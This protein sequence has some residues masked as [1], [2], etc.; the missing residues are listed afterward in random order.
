MKYRFH[1]C[2]VF[3]DRMF[4]GNQLA[5][6]PEAEGLSTDQMQQLTREFNFSEC[7]FVLPP[8]K[9]GSRRVRIFTPEREVP[10]AGHPNVGTAFVLLTEG[11]AES[12]ES[13]PLFFE[14]PAGM[15][16]V[17]FRKNGGS[18]ICELEA[19]EAFSTGIRL[20]PA[21]VAPSV[22]LSPDD[23]KT[24]VHM[25]E[26]ASVGFPFLMTEL[27]SVDALRRAEPDLSAMKQL[28]AVDEHLNIHLYVRSSDEYDLRTR[29]FAPLD[30]IFE[31]PATG[32]ANCA[33]AAYLA[34][35]E[36][37]DSCSLDLRI[38]Q[39]IEMGRPSLLQAR[40]LKEQG[41][42]VS[43]HIGGNCVMVTS[44]TVDLQE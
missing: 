36:P 12:D 27:V 34:S 4:G 10:F 32:S 13:K 25:P 8:E 21:Q 9:G 28:K 42:V 35:L 37:D 26:Q 38:G 40:A 30:G 22:G 11:Y 33:L 20:D 31:D 3:T 24:S 2:D 23:I 7:T 43:A 18:Y 16:P 39:G 1:T 17:S 29:M 19:P 15:V 14:E 44:G 41:R 5:V 6:F